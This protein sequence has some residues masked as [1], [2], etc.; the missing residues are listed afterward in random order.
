MRGSALA[1]RA[2]RAARASAVGPS[3]YGPSMSTSTVETRSSRTARHERALIRA[4]LLEHRPDLVGRLQEGPSGALLIPLPG[5]RAIEIGRM[6][7]RGRARWVVA[8]PAA[9]GAR[10]WEPS[11]L[12]TVVLV[13]LSALRSTELRR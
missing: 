5:G 6:R 1:A 4:L 13:A 3:A 8:G 10:L 9:D 2:A 7:R 11:T 12:P